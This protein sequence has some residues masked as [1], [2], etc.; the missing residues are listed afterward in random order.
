VSPG[1]AVVGPPLGYAH[2]VIGAHHYPVRAGRGGRRDGRR[3]ACRRS[4]TRRSG[5][6][7]QAYE[8]PR[9]A[10][11]RGDTRPPAGRALERP[12]RRKQ[13]EE[14]HGC[15]A[16]FFHPFPTHLRASSA[17]GP[18]APLPVVSRL[19]HHNYRIPLRCRQRTLPSSRSTSREPRAR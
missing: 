9:P 4:T 7:L 1:A 3:V 17:V 18:K 19:I 14:D 2:E 10:R 6:N 15:E 16:G 13:R 11:S 5:W 12:A 8:R